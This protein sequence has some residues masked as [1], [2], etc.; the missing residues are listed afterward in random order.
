M[1]AIVFAKCQYLFYRSANFM[2][3]LCIVITVQLIFNEFL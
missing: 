3:L 1:H 2:M